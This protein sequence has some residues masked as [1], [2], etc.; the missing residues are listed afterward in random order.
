MPRIDSTRLLA[1]L[2]ALRGFGHC[3]TGLHR[4]A[5][6]APDIAARHWLASRMAEAA[7]APR[8]DR[9][10]TLLGRCAA[11]RSLLIGS[12]TDTVPQG[13]WLDGALG[14]VCAL[15]VA[16][17]LGNEIDVISFQDEEGTFLPCLGSRSVIGVLTPAEID[18]ARAR[19]GRT[20]AAALAEGEL[21]GAPL[22]AEPGRY[23]G[24]LELHIE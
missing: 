15:E 22:Q 23:R 2:A 5:H 11:A 21:H 14:V 9:H 8:M 17:T 1:D 18:A 24:F 10:G 12:H 7:L 6:S 4:P 3:G 19:D 20:L 16:R 13:G